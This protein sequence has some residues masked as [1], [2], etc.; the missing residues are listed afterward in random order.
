MR[1]LEEPLLDDATQGPLSCAHL[2]SRKRSGCPRNYL[3]RQSPNRQVANA[4]LEAYAAIAR[5]GP[6][7]NE[8]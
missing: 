3:W 7:A 1:A 6:L 5:S 8:D 2:T 4:E